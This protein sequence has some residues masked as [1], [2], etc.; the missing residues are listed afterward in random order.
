MAIWPAQIFGTYQNPASPRDSFEND[1]YTT[2]MY[3]GIDV[4]GTKTLVA[5]LDDDGVITDQA[6][7]P[8]PQSYAGFLDELTKNVASLT[9]NDLIATGVGIP[10]TRFDRQDGVGL[11]FGNLDWRNVPIRQDVRQLVNTPVV[12]ENDA[13]L[14]GLSE[15]MLLKDY[16]KVLYV[17][18]STGIGTALIDHGQIDTS[19]GDA[20][21][22]TLL[23]Q[24][25]GQ[26]TPWESYASG[27]A[28]VERF[29]KQAKDIHDLDTWQQIVHDWTA[30]FLELIAIMEPNVIVIGGSVGDYFDRY[31]QL[32]ETSLKRYET[33]LMPIPPLTQAKR[34]DEA[35]VYGAYDLAK[36]TY[37]KDS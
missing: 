15:A 20:G 21:G 11:E 6:K 13:K 32:L 23:L 37:G 4:G 9:T 36:Q 33:P 18:I 2:I 14:A 12:V 29:G 24:H 7:F 28:I 25:H 1:C 30:G 8:T 31:G 19:V 17:T 22:R 3:L 35:V 16:A 5:T 34:P 27:H 10:V 26:L